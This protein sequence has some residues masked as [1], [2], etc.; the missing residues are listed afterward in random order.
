MYPE[1]FRYGDF[2]ISSFGLMMVI[3]FIA[4]NYILRKDLVKY[5]YDYNIADDLIFRSAIGGIIGAKLYYIVESGGIENLQGIYNIFDG[6]VSFSWETFYHK[7]IM[8]FGSGLV[9]L[10]GLIGGLLLVT[11]YLRKNSLDWLEFSDYAGPLLALGHSIGRVGCLLVGDDYGRPTDLP[12]GISFKNG[13][14]PSTVEN[15]RSMG[16]QFSDSLP[17]NTICHVHPT[18]IYECILYF[19]I[20]LY[21]RY[22]F[23]YKD[24]NGEI[25][26]NY[27]FLVGFSR[28]LIEFL[29]LNPKYY[30]N[31]SGAQYISLLMILIASIFLYRFRQKKYKWKM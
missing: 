8:V 16:Y 11:H 15:I 21:L 5:G 2:V 28:F 14:P 22:L 13:L 18:Q 19:I 27:L 25:F 6:L 23:K 4:C 10:G 31:L 12:W 26:F 29:R 24:F 17:L 1:I 9:F 30:L 20:F 7:G 3:A